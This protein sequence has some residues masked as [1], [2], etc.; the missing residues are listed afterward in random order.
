[1]CK[2][3]IITRN[4]L[5]EQ[6]LQQQLQH[7]GHEV[8]CTGIDTCHFKLALFVEIFDSIILSETLSN[9]ETQLI[10]QQVNLEEQS[11]EVLR[12][13]EILPSK[14]QSAEL[15]ELGIDSYL[16]ICATLEELREK[17]ATK[18]S[19]NDANTIINFVAKRPYSPINLAKNEK[20]LMTILL[21]NAGSCVERNQICE[22]IWGI[23]PT[24]SSM[25]QLSALIKKIQIKFDG[26]GLEQK[27][28][29]TYWGRGYQ[30]NPQAVEI[31]RDILHPK[32]NW[33]QHQSL[34][35]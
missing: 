23:Q 12:K 1:M 27:L 5:V 15:T 3:M 34:R 26:A 17:Y 7:L 14:E 11:I 10:L 9:E 22:A 35:A 16:S 32:E 8:F 30:L 29:L 28:V 4:I 25:S 21:E 2:I 18:Q 20:K 19:S 31:V 24:N 13:V 33:H 6:N